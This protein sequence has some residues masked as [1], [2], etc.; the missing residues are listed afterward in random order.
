MENNT[1]PPQNVN[2]ENPST[3]PNIEGQTPP[4]VAQPQTAPQVQN[5][6]ASDPGS[7]LTIVGIIAGFILTPIIG[8]ILSLVAYKKSKKA[9]F[10]NTLAKIFTWIFGI[11]SILVGVVV[12]IV[13]GLMVF[14]L[15]TSRSK[16]AT[17]LNDI[18]SGDCTSAAQ[19]ADLTGSD[20]ESFNTFCEQMKPILGT[21][22]SL[23]ESSIEN[24]RTVSLYS[25]SGGTKKYVRVTVKNG[26]V[27]NAVASDT[28][29]PTT[30]SS[31]DTST[32]NV[33][34][35]DLSQ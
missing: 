12:A 1:I 19:M 3:P 35:N 9:G 7:T 32:E 10:N 31:T 24:S 34:Q 13:I 21:S 33:N 15:T 18:R 2:Q 5:Q 29:L 17:F 23:V 28:Q 14:G 22:Q 30:E 11:F 20:S 27:L 16:A 25:I 8:F 6:P 4:V 26:K